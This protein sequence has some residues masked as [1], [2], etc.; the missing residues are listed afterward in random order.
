[1]HHEEVER[2]KRQYTDQYV[3]V[4]AGRPELARFKDVVGQ[5]KTVNMSGRA[6]VEFDAD[7][8]RGWYD[9]EID[10]LKVVDK[11][12]PKPVQ[13]VEKKPAAAAAAKPAGK[14]TSTARP[15]QSKEESP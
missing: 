12:P 5:V 11:P 3:V 7:N 6:L 15:P 9:V 13:K 10:C 14:E 4:D 8:N 2:L 1:M